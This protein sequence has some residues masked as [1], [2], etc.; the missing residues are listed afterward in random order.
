MVLQCFLDCSVDH[1]EINVFQKCHHLLIITETPVDHLQSVVLSH[2]E[3]QWHHG[4]SLF[5]SL[6]LGNGVRTVCRETFSRTARWQDPPST[7]RNPSFMALR[8]IIS[9][10]LTPSMEV[11]VTPGF[12]SVTPCN[13]C[14]THS[15]PARVDNANW[16]GAVAAMVAGPNC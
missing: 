3:E 9:Y 6:P 1:S 2:R 4:A 14:A 10:A 16:W 11:T 8:E 7:R 5:P 12:S 15:Q 13:M